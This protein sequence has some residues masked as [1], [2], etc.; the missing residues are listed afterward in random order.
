MKLEWLPQAAQYGS[1]T[2]IAKCYPFTSMFSDPYHAQ[3]LAILVAQQAAPPAS[4]LAWLG[5][6]VAAFRRKQ[7]IGGWLFFF[8]WQVVAGC[9]VTVAYTDWS[10]F[11]PR[12]WGD[13]TQ[14]LVFVLATAP[15]VATLITL[16][17]LGVMLMRTYDWRWVLVI[18]YTLI[19]F[20]IFGGISVAADL[21][22]FPSR[23]AADVGLLIF[24]VAF[25]IYFNV[26][27][28]VRGVFRDRMWNG[29]AV[30]VAD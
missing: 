7:P 14:Y 5:A 4:S 16:A 22:F 26:S 28:R 18:K 19:I 2:V 25:A 10:R 17:A 13:Q 27:V 11:T 6:V 20:A 23:V 29:R 12:T 3:A 1:R 15:K 30:G 21:R 24:P 8:F 9:A